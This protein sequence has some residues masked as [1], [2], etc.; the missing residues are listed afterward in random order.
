MKAEQRPWLQVDVQAK[1]GLSW[2]GTEIGGLMTFRLINNGHSPALNVRGFSNT[3]LVWDDER[4][5]KYD[6]APWGSSRIN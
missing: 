4:A 6:L 5:Q 1:R 3:L 2:A